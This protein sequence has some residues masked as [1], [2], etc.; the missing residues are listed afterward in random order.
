MVPKQPKGRT[1]VV[2]GATY[3]LQ[4]DLAAGEFVEFW[5][6]H[7]A[8]SLRPTLMGRSDRFQRV[9]G[10]RVVIVGPDA[11]SSAENSTSS[12]AAEAVSLLQKIDSDLAVEEAL[13]DQLMKR[14]G[15]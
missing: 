2:P 8:T 15:L 6:A 7:D 14:H 1:Y 4:Q 9:T 3:V 13:V 12:E 11:R 5:P 10:S